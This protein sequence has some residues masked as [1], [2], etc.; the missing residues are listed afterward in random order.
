MTKNSLI[1]MVLGFFTAV[2]LV[3]YGVFIENQIDVTRA[4]SS[5][6]CTSCLGIEEI[7]PE[8]T[9]HEKAELTKVE[10]HVQIILF[11]MKGCLECPKAHDYV[12]SVCEAS[13]GK[14]SY[15]EIDVTVNWTMAK[16]YDIKYVPSIV[17]GNK[18]L[19]GLK[20][21][22]EELISAIIEFSRT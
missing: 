6:I 4:Y 13:N 16:E 17:V 11:T 9:F 1:F 15:I 3:I 14:V 8:L 5:V 12:E 20:A 22:H 18:K 7:A 21:I 2:L 10:N 19:E